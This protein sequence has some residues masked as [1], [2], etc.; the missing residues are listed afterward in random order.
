MKILQ[1]S[2]S[3]NPCHEA[4][5]VVKVAYEIS[6]CL[7]ERGHQVTVVTTDGCTQRLNVKKNTEV[8]LE[9]VRVWYFRNISNYLR[10]KF[11][12]A[13]PYLLPFYL[14]KH[15]KDFDIIHIHEHRTILAVIVSHYA[16]KFNIPYVIHGHGS[17]SR[18]TSGKTLKKI[19]DI[20]FGYSIIKGAARLIAVSNEEATHYLQFTGK[21]EDIVILYNGLDTDNF[22][23]LPKYGLFKEKYGIKGKMVLFLGRI[24]KTKGLDFAVKAFSDIAKELDDAILVIAGPDDGYK[25]DIERL[26]HELHMEN[27]IQFVGYLDAKDKVTAY[28]DS[29]PFVHTALYM[30]GVGLAP[31][32]VILCRSPVVVTPECGEIIIQSNSGYIVQYGDIEGLKEVMRYVLKNP[33]NYD[34]IRRGIEFIY[35]NLTWDK[36][37]DVLE[38]LY[39][40]IIG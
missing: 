26:I 34:M 16:K 3:F 19:F 36:Y 10:I 31:L 40:S 8:D 25:S 33:I 24:N 32:E 29:D 37:I 38:E 6:R 7:V 21:S 30:G 2:H 1:I 28:V 23:D 14:K 39:Q 4:G 20:C 22:K 35:E 17:I 18:E 12:F 13:T 9:G 27:K 5:G 15:I 11:K